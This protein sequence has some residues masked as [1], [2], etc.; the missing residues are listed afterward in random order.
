MIDPEIRATR[1]CT[2]CGI[3]GDHTCSRAE[4]IRTNFAQLVKEK[5]SYWLARKIMRMESYRKYDRKYPY[6][7]TTKAK[8]IDELYDVADGSPDPLEMVL[9]Q[10]A[11]EEYLAQLTPAQQEAAKLYVQ[12][13]KPRDIA[14]MQ[15]RNNSG[16]ERWQKHN[17][18]E[19]LLNYL[20]NKQD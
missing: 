3:L 5:G 11:Q 19:R 8:P 9:M 20:H 1:A 2:Y 16:A 18:K 7:S 6:D 12:G 13:Y 14:Q 4:K 10:E 15:G 17:M